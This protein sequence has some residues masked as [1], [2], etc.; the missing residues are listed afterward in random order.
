VAAAWVLASAAPARGAAP[1]YRVVVTAATVADPEW[2][3][4]VD[5]LA[6]RHLAP[7]DVA[8]AGFEELLPTWRRER[9]RYVGFVLRPTEAT[10]RQVGALH[11]LMRRVDDDPYPDALWG[12]VT[13]FDAS[14]ALDLV[15]TTAPLT[16]R[17]VAGGTEV[18][19]SCCDSGVWYCELKAGRRV[20]K[21]PGGIPA[22]STGPVDTTEVLA[23]ALT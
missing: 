8:A 23:K 2:R 14:N 4:V 16:I 11:R 6:A 15:R 12:I 22:E 10:R 13:G 20:R 7:V 3:R 17:K 1:A 9:P 21:E 5:A 19:L 18:A